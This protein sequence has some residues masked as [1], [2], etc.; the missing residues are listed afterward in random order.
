[1][2]GR[3]HGF[4]FHNFPSREEILEACHPDYF[5]GSGGNNTTFRIPAYPDLIVRRSNFIPKSLSLKHLEDPRSLPDPFQGVNVGQPIAR[6]GAYITVNLRQDG[7][8]L[9]VKN[10]ERVM[11]PRIQDQKSLA[12]A[13]E[14]IEGGCACS[15]LGCRTQ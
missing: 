6:Y 4:S 10:L 13:W 15:R 11:K 3:S 1:M 9:A 2:N 5:H 7:Q 8:P 12:S 14:I